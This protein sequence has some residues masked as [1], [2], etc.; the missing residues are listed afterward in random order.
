MFPVLLVM[1]FLGRISM[2]ASELEVISFFPFYFFF[3]DPSIILSTMALVISAF[4]CK[5]ISTILFMIYTFNW[6]HTV[7]N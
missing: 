7:N 5:Y 1:V 4:N 3:D 6:K 2:D